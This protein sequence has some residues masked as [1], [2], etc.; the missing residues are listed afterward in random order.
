MDQVAL[1]LKF[2]ILLLPNHPHR[3]VPQR[4]MLKPACDNLSGWQKI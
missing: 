1:L 4:S 2:S 3:G